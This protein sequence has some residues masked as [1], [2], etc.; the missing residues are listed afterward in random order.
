[1]RF[2]LFINN[3][4]INSLKD[5]FYGLHCFSLLKKV[6]VLHRDHTE[7]E[8]WLKCNYSTEKFL[9]ALVQE[10]IMSKDVAEAHE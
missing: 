6:A 7:L 2:C 5:V 10:R 9:A 1:M 8:T 4:F 3:S